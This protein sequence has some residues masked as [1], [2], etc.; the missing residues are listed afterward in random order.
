MFSVDGTAA[1]VL[2]TK[3][4]DYGEKPGEAGLYQMFVYCRTLGIG[5]AVLLYPNDSA[6][7]DRYEFTEG[8]VVEA[9]AVSLTGALWVFQKRWEQWADELLGRMEREAAALPQ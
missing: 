4:K 5:R 9:R 1:L 8:T 7:D 6:V 2:D 3:Y